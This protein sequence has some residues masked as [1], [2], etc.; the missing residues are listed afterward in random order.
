MLRAVA[1][2][3]VSVDSI[4]TTALEIIVLTFEMLP[5]PAKTNPEVIKEFFE[6]CFSYMIASVE[7]IDQEWLS[8]PEGNLDLF[9][10]LNM[11]L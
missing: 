10:F 6:S 9:F 2:T 3:N 7:D 1:A 8:P 5:G 4:K 11:N